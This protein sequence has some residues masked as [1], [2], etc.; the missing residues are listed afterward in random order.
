MALKFNI[1]IIVFI[2]YFSIKIFF[3][4]NMKKYLVHKYW[5][6]KN[7]T[8]NKKTR[9]NFLSA[10]K[11]NGKSCKTEISSVNAMDQLKGVRVVDCACNF[12]TSAFVSST[13]KLHLFGRLSM[14]LKTSNNGLWFLCSATVLDCRC[15]V[16][17][18]FRWV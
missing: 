13:G 8:F 16:I 2:F 15:K 7:D 9:V 4:L 14:H 1:L 12:G 3:F 18:R 10:W 6:K 5:I 17:N 11:V